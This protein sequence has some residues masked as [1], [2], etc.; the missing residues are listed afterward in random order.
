MIVLDAYAVLAF[1]KGEPAAPEVRSLLHGDEAAVL[2]VLG[3]AEVVDHLVVAVRPPL[4]SAPLLELP[5]EEALGAFASKFWGAYR[6]IREARS[7]F[8]P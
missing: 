1:L 5:P 6:L 8:P 7:R 3:A 4:R 2:T